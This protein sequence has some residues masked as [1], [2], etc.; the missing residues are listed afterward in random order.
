MMGRRDEHVQNL[1]KVGGMARTRESLEKFAEFQ[2]QKNWKS[3]QWF[4]A[5]YEQ[6]GLRMTSDQFNIVF[7]PFIPDCVNHA[8]RYVIEVDGSVHDRKDVK[9]RDL[10]KTAFYQSQGYRVFRVKAF[11]ESSFQKFCKKLTRL[12][13]ECLLHGLPVIRELRRGETWGNRKKR[14]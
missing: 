9:E 8:Y 10:R 7:G 12:H 3:E 2:R 4:L 14:S 5:L 13:D 11:V 1:R 6:S